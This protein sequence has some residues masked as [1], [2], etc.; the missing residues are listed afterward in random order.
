MDAERDVKFGAQALSTQP[1]RSSSGGTAVR[2]TAENK[3]MGKPLSDTEV[4]AKM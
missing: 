4:Y 1:A 3:E 2:I